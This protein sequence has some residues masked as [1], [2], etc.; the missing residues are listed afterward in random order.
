MNIV[1]ACFALA[2]AGSLCGCAVGPNFAKPAAPAGAG[3]GP[4]ASQTSSS[5]VQQGEAQRFVQD[6]DMPGQ[7]W[8]AFGSQP[9]NALIEKA[10]KANPTITAA[11]ATLRAA[12][13]NVLAQQGA[14]YPTVTAGLSDARNLTPARALSPVSASGNPY[15]SLFTGQLSIS[16]TPDVFG[17]NRRTVESLAAEAEKQR[18]QLEATYLSLTANLVAAAVQEALLHDLIGAQQDTIRAD[19]E[20]R[21]IMRGQYTAGELAQADLLA[22]EAVLAQ[23]QQA[24][25]PLQSQLAQKRHL[26]AALA[27][28][29]PND[30]VADD[31][32]LASLHLPQD[33]PVSVSSTLVEQRPDIRAAAASMQAASAQIGITIAN[34][35][36]QVSLTASLGTS[37]NNITNAFTPFNQFF[38]LAAGLVQPI[39][40]G[41]TLRHRQRAVEAEFDVSVAQYRST[42]IAAF[43]N[44]ADVLVALQSDADA[45]QAALQSERAAVRSVEIAQGQLRLGEGSYLSVLTA[46]QLYQTSRNALVQAQAR[47]LSDTAALFAALG[48]G[49]WNRDDVAPGCARGADWQRSAPRAGPR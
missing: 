28:G 36:P 1:M 49:W 21:D 38:T 5:S 33:L 8:A 7:W 30:P 19:T 9:L 40:D 43:Q 17:L 23:A 10:L 47:R 34:R 25:I 2:L 39:F 35:L 16:Y 45:L 4:L 48:G 11:Q 13:E 6:M 3:Y 14:F 18:F 32:D 27:G 12:H 26:M 31:F 44:V 37:P 24:L 46:E 42:L 29:F 20:I 41:G 15:Y 22:Q